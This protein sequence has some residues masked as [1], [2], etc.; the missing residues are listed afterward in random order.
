MPSV[1]S[2]PPPLR[3]RSASSINW[4]FARASREKQPDSFR[5]LY[6]Q[7]TERGL[8]CGPDDD[9]KFQPV[10]VPRPPQNTTLKD[11]ASLFLMPASNC[12]QTPTPEDWDP[13]IVISSQRDSP[14]SNYTVHS[15]AV[16]QDQLFDGSCYPN[17]SILASQVIHNMQKKYIWV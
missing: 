10:S 12:F 4:R 13:G 9:F 7:D 5:N 8:D 14:G 15:R 6:G 2:A 1:S 3:S 17:S 16:N 11:S